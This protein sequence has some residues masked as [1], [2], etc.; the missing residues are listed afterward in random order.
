MVNMLLIS[1]KEADQELAAV[2]ERQAAKR[3]AEQWTDQAKQT[4][5]WNE[6]K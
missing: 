5:T 1:L 3:R 2:E 4:W 6:M